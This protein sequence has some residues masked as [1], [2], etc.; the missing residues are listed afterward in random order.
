MRGMGA[1]VTGGKRPIPLRIRLIKASGASGSTACSALHRGCLAGSLINSRIRHA[2]LYKA[3][4][5]QPTGIATSAGITL[6]IGRIT[7]HCQP[8]VDTQIYAPTDD[9]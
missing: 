1:N 4:P 2:G 3:L 7:G 8:E 9:L 5:A 6:C